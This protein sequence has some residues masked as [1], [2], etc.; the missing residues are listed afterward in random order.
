MI[1]SY[2]EHASKVREKHAS[3]A[4]LFRELLMDATKEGD[5]R[6]HES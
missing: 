4:S 5:K 6:I 2:T 1:P 3:H